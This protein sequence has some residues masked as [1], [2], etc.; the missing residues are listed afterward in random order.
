MEVRTCL[1]GTSI[2]TAFVILRETAVRN[3]VFPEV[4]NRLRYAHL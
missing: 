1:Y 2:Q 3:L 4:I